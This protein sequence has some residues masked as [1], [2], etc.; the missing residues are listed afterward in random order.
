MG[1][2]GG[3]AVAPR[4]P[5][6]RARKNGRG[7]A[8]RGRW[9]MANK[10]LS[11]AKIAK[12]DEYYTQMNDIQAEI[13]AYLDFDENTFR[14]K[15]VLLPCDDPRES[16]TALCAQSGMRQTKRGCGHSM[17]WTPTMSRRGRKVARPT[18]R[19][20]RCS[21]RRTTE[22]RETAS[23]FHGCASFD[24]LT[25]NSDESSNHRCD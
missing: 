18:P 14:G 4:P 2:G 25:G 1:S 10:N 12:Q 20:A 7:R 16:Q 9:H 6:Q 5:Q 3:R 19:T 8:C 21:A 23:H 15:T 17:K 22:P 24:K 11:A 13:N